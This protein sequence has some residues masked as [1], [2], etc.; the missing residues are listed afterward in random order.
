MRCAHVGST[1][2]DDDH[3]RTV[4][5]EWTMQEAL[6]QVELDLFEDADFISLD[7]G[8]DFLKEDVKYDVVILHH[9]YQHPGQGHKGVH[10][11]S[12]FHAPDV[13]RAR[14]AG[15]NAG[16]IFAYGGSTEVSGGYLNEIPGYEMLSYDHIKAVYRKL[17]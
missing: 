6:N 7:D 11:T 10:G 9:I 1:E 3:E 14:L 5:V 16:W 15:T 4:D 13:W 2:S 8:R 12:P 17:A